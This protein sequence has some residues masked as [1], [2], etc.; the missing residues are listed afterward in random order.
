MKLKLLLLWAAV[1]IAASSP[2][3]ADKAGTEVMEFDLR[4]PDK[5]LQLITGANEWEIY[6]SGIIDDDAPARLLALIKKNNIPPNSSISLNSPGGSLMAGMKL[7][8]LIR[9]RGFTTEIERYNAASDPHFVPGKCF[10]A[11]TLAFLG[12]TWRYM[13]PGSLYGV[14]RFYFT[15]PTGA[16]S[17]VAQMLSAVVIQYIRDM[18]VDPELFS[19]MSTAGKDDITL[20]PERELERLD[21]VNNGQTPTVWSV[22]SAQGAVYL[23][24]QRNTA[25]G[26]NKFILVCVSNGVD[27]TVVMDPLAQG[28]P[29]PPSN[30]VS[31]VADDKG[32]PIETYMAEGPVLNN[33]SV[34]AS[35][36]LPPN[37]VRVIESAHEVG[38]TFQVSRDSP[39]FVGFRGM[40]FED[41]AKKMSGVL[42]DCLPN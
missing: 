26:V 2:V 42:R 35:F 36:V 3:C 5:M 28:D 16:D 17:D 9:S 37:I 11:C 33:G 23:K 7:G 40:R 6:A 8:K 13:R 25:F 19:E 34:F 4:P 39:T 30:A 32:F 24:G 31:L 15:K 22:V 29:L 10:S 41:G 21:V 14:H 27:L 20:I 18:G 12:G 1:V 38:I